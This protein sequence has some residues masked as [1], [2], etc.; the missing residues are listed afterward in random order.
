MVFE[1]TDNHGYIATEYNGEME[2]RLAYIADKIK[3][4]RGY[5]DA[6]RK[7]KALLVDTGDKCQYS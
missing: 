1:T 3:D 5:G 7:E 4:V 2:Y 6:Y